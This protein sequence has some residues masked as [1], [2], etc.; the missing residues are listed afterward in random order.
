MR[1]YFETASFDGPHAQELAELAQHGELELP[2]LS[3]A[4]SAVMAET[5]KADWDAGRIVGWLK[6]DPALAAHMLRRAS[7]VALGAVQP[8]AS[9]QQAVARLGATQLRQLAVMIACESRVFVAPGFEAEVST[10]FRHSLA[11]ALYAQELA[12]QRRDNVEEA[13]MAGLLHDVGWPVLLQAIVDW[14]KKRGVQLARGEV[15][16]AVERYHAQVAERL[17]AK[18][19][20]PPRLG[21]AMRGH[22]APVAESPVAMHTVSLADGLARLAGRADALSAEVLKQSPSVSALNIYPDVFDALAAKGP[23]IWAKAGA[24]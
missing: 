20:L 22:H 4:A 17:V 14:Q 9:L 8:V 12:R 10:L 16:S 15:L 18:W 2:V 19:G 21:L 13:F 3:D 23:T 5:A 11:T 24:A 6:N 7:S 1:V